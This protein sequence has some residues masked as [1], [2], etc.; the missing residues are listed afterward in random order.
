MVQFITLYSFLI[1]KRLEYDNYLK[2]NNI[3]QGLYYEN[4]NVNFEEFIQFGNY[5]NGHF[6]G[7]YLLFYISGR[8][9]SIETYNNGI[10]VGP[11]LVFYESSNLQRYICTIINNCN[12]YITNY[13]WFDNT[14]IGLI[15][16]YKNDTYHGIN[17]EWYNNGQIAKKGHWINSKLRGIYK[18]WDYDGNLIV[19]EI[20]NIKIEN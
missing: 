10:P 13:T 4:Y 7:K 6:H 3:K 14:K 20:N 15:H 1:R 18:E 5:L 19:Y 11:L 12:T 2:I 16:T 8:L 17:C 9:N